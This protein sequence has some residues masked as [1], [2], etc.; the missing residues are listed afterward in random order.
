MASRKLS[1]GTLLVEALAARPP[2]S[3]IS[4]VYRVTPCM[5]GVNKYLQKTF[6]TSPQNYSSN[7][8][9]SGFSSDGLSKYFSPVKYMKW[10]MGKI[11]TGR[12]VYEMCSTQYD[13]QP[14]LSQ[15][16]KLES[17]F[18]AWFSLTVLHIW[19]YGVR[20]RAEGQSGKEMNQ[21]IVDHLW[22][23]VEIQ[24][25]KAGVRFK[26]DSTVQGLLSGYYGQILAYDEG[27][28]R[29]DGVLAAAIWRNVYGPRP[30]NAS[31]LASLVSYVRQQLSTLDHTPASDLL[32]GK[33]SFQ[34]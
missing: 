7:S 30:I 23:D 13:K 21:E 27:L 28:A 34:I 29:G 8:E 4:S 11:D 32:S 31:Q 10:R 18:Q 2:R 25:A 1:C 5:Q 15:D 16:A 9:N 12:N 17:N 24:L 19:M 14:W 6:F 20:L 3:V 33:F 22:L 26:I